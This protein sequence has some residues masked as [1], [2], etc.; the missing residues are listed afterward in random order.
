[1]CVCV[2]GGG[3]GGW[4][5]VGGR[6]LQARATPGPCGCRCRRDAL[7]AWR[8]GGACTCVCPAPSLP[9]L[10]PH[11]PV[12][13][14]PPSH[15]PPP[16]CPPPSHLKMAAAVPGTPTMPVPST[17]TSDTWSMVA[18]P[19]TPA[20]SPSS[21]ASSSQITVPGADCGE[22]VDRGREEGGDG[23]RHADSRSGGPCQQ[24]PRR[25]AGMSRRS[26]SR[27]LPAPGWRP[28]LALPPLAQAA[29]AP[30]SR[31]RQH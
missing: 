5:A 26:A 11:H 14:S 20:T 17:L 1:V 12:A 4:A 25:G 7:L 30:T 15:L 19:L 8:A 9:R 18:K 16:C 2:G 23:R 13:A 31:P 28:K 29:K 6:R 27:C 21:A 22:G 10:G 3:Q 24:S